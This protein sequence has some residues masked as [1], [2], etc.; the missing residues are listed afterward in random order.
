MSKT[1]SKAS[2]LADDLKPAE[3]VKE[4]S[5][6]GASKSI[7][8]S[9]KASDE[10]VAHVLLRVR[11]EE[12]QTVSGHTAMIQNKGRAMLGKLGQPIGPALVTSLKA[13]I[14]TGQKTY[15]FLTLREGWNGQYV[16]YKCNLRDIHKELSEE[17]EEFAPRYYKTSWYEV[18]TW[19][20]I[21]SMQK[22]DREDMN[23]IFVISSGREI[24]SVIKSSA[25]VFIVG[26]P[27]NKN[28]Q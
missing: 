18:V 27:E 12:G 26:W 9:G 3:S 19:F 4:S 6:K 17:L 5:S 25:S 15:L 22:M 1:G 21:E 13:Q 8:E 23:R 24:M 14:A 28:K 20:E 10:T 11:S 2:K 7:P 16:T